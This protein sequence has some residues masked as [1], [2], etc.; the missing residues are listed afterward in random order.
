MAPPRPAFS[1]VLKASVER[2]DQ[3]RGWCDRCKRYQ[4]LS[5]RKTIQSIPKVL[6]VNTAIHSP[7]HKQLWSTPGWL[8][9]EIGVVVQNGQFFCYEGSDLKYHLQRGFY[10]IMVYELV[11]M[12]VD[13]N[14]ADNQKSHLVSLINVA[15]SSPDP[16]DQDQWHLFNDFLV[17]STTSEE[18]L[19]FDMNWKLPSI[20][21]YQAKSASHVID[22]SWKENLDP[23]LLYYLPRG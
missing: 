5:T 11:G 3:T 19:R 15:P 8:P 22:D 17:R 14:S 2:Q 16:A 10:D 23:S 7:D 20:L 13:I 18:A 1:Q 6:M 12:V 9:Q 4:Q 21:T